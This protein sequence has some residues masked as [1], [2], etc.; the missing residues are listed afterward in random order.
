[1]ES[2]RQGL[3]LAEDRAR[4]LPADKAAAA[5]DQLAA[6]RLKSLTGRKP[7]EVAAAALEVAA[8]QRELGP[9]AVRFLDALVRPQEP[10]PR[11]VET[12]TLRRLAELAATPAAWP[13]AAAGQALLVA[14]AGER[15]AARPRVFPWVEGL[16]ERAAGL[17]HDGEMLLEAAGY[18]P[19]GAAGRSS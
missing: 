3:S 5:L 19:P 7:E 13:G 11:F 10:L 8:D 12:A 15:A 6:E 2:V 1:V 14:R 9:L 16:L 4:D 17:R 18:V